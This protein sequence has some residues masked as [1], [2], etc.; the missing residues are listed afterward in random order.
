MTSGF[1]PVSAE[2]SVRASKGWWDAS[3]EDYQKSRGDQLGDATFSWGPEGLTEASAH[4]LGPVAGRRILEVGGGAGQCSRWLT[5]QGAQAVTLDLSLQQLHHSQSL[6]A[7]HG[8]AVPAVNADG[9]Q[10][11]LADH[12][13]DAAFAS[14][15]ALQFVADPERVMCE[16]R[17]VLKPGGRWAFSVTHPIRWAFPDD[18]T[19]HGLTACR[20][21]FDTTP[22]AERDTHGEVTYVEH[23]RTL[24][25]WLTMTAQSG[26]VIDRVVEPEWDDPQRPDWDGW[27]KLRGQ[28]I[29]GTL[30]V[31]GHTYPAGPATTES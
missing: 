15:G 16:V 17:R 12:S 14:Y 25:E 6:D 13:F 26:F 21:Y 20:S 31:A 30:I 18:P 28:Y 4:I 19:K 5:S 23:H 10:L 8:M 7:E 27:S 2:E 3:A 1:F 11:P 9:R 29:P 22:Y 24:G